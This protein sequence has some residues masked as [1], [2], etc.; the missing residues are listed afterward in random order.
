[1]PLCFNLIACS[2]GDNN[3]V[4][5]VVNPV[6]LTGAA[7][8]DCMLTGAGCSGNGG[9]SSLANCFCGTSIDLSPLC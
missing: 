4:S 6:A 9:V 2:P 7:A 3:A 1:M 8:I 5:V